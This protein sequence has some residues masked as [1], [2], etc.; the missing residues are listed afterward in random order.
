MET[1]LDLFIEQGYDQTTIEEIAER[2]E[3]KSE[4]VSRIEN[5]SALPDLVTM[6]KL[7]AALGCTYGALLDPV[8]AAPSPGDEAKLL[9]AW[10]A[11]DPERRDIALR[12]VIAMRQPDGK[13]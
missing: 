10:R 6:A 9:D 8:T 5:G 1:A 3:V 7:V 11:L 2:A 12:A 4:T 13:A